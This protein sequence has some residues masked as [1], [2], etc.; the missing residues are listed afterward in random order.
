MGA[1]HQKNEAVARQDFLNGCSAMDR[2]CRSVDAASTKAH[3]VSQTRVLS[4]Q[5]REA[6][7][8]NS[9][10]INA[11]R[12]VCRA[13][14]QV[15]SKEERDQLRHLL[16]SRRSADAQ[17]E[18]KIR[19]SMRALKSIGEYLNHAKQEI[20][21]KADDVDAHARE[22]D[23][24]MVR[25]GK[26]LATFREMSHIVRHHGEILSTHLE[27]EA[28]N[29]DDFD[30][31]SGQE[32]SRGGVK[33]P[34]SLAISVSAEQ[35]TLQA[36]YR[37]GEELFIDALEEERPEN[38]SDSEKKT[39]VVASEAEELQRQQQRQRRAWNSTSL[40]DSQSLVSLAQQL[41]S[42]REEAGS[43]A[44]GSCR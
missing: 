18:E 15:H 21:T 26:T 6:W 19:M 12:A 10:R 30:N 24:D 43:R 29:G 25:Y 13:Q 28:S 40:L 7:T 16:R 44:L 34:D 33:Q 5:K 17:Q 23:S 4:K 27:G 38:H 2:R 42:A 31:A 3:R 11:H 9:K 36:L 32:T 14:Q 37:V 41:S 1:T 8:A 20:A 39:V 22:G 35:Q